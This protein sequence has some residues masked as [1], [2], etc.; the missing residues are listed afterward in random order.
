[1]TAPCQ[2][3]EPDNFQIDGPVREYLQTRH[4]AIGSFLGKQSKALG[5]EITGI[6][7]LEYE[8]LATSLQAAYREAEVCCTL[9]YEMIVE[10]FAK[11][12]EITERLGVGFENPYSGRCGDYSEFFQDR[13]EVLWDLLGRVNLPYP[14]EE[15]DTEI[16]IIP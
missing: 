2:V 11:V 10:A 1:M 15:D 14:R 16:G 13:A 8:H 6:T 4:L 12:R 7:S 9:R 3:P 5:G